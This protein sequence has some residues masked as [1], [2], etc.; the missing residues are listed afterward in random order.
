[1]NTSLKIPVDKQYER[2]GKEYRIEYL[3]RQR[4]WLR[5]KIKYTINNAKYGILQYIKST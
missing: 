4:L 2:Y 3:H 5:Y 1:M